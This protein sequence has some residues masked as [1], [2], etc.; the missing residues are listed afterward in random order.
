MGGRGV[1]PKRLQ[2][3]MRQMGIKMED[4]EDVEEVVIRT[5]DKEYVFADAEVSKM[6][7]QGQVTWQLAGEPT[8]RP[9][10]PAEPVKIGY[11]DEDVKL[12]MEQAKVSEKQ[13]RDAL[14]AANGQPAEAIM[15]LIEEDAD[16]A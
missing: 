4:I 9:R 14:D 6:T 13:A 3:M 7:A 16:A 1:D 10:A 11:S 15:K 5:K 12:V 2:A 8:I